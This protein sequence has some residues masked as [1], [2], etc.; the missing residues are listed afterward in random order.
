VLTSEAVVRTEHPDRY[1]GRLRGHTAKMRQ[2]GGHWPRRHG[3]GEEPPE[4]QHAEWS[5]DSGAIT[6]PWG[7]WTVQAD[8]GTL[9]LRAEADGPDDLRR[10]QRM[11][12]ARLES[13]GR[14]EHL[15]VTW[16]PPASPSAQPGQEG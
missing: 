6:L 12:T 16:Q 14:R 8:P 3:S 4:V 13:F 11:L 15:T 7:R 5:G 1:L 9:T 2:H 10:I